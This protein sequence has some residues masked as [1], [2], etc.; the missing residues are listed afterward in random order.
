MLGVMIRR[1]CTTDFQELHDFFR[2]VITDTFI[3]EGIGDQVDDI[4]KEI[5]TKKNYLKS[6]FASDGKN[7]TF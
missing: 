7:D 6:D 1:P 4:Q 3:K 5:E 2:L